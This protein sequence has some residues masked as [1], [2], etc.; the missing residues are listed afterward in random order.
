M[1]YLRVVDQAGN[2]QD[3]ETEL[4]PR[5]GERIILEYGVGGAT[6]RPHFL[7]VKDVEYRL[8]NE[9]EHQVAVLVEEEHDPEHWPS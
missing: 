5:I 3:H 1:K 6:V 7:R 2:K 9:P 8:D 4:V